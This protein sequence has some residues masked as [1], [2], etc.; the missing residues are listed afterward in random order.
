M[1]VPTPK[2]RLFFALWPD[3][4]VRQRM[5]EARN[6]LPPG[7]GR[8]VPATNLHLTLVF[9]G[10]VGD[11]VALC[12]RQAASRLHNQAFMLVLNKLGSWKKQQV[13][14]LAP[15]L[16]PEALLSLVDNLQAALQQCGLV[17][18]KRAFK[19]HVSVLRKLHQHIGPH[20]L[21]PISW[22]IDCFCLVESLPVAEGVHYH[23]VQSWQ[24]TK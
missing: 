12:A 14:W 21:Q 9:L 10:D 8:C 6:G 23:V 16:V 24:L 17:P 15:T 20:A 2:R 22:S 4:V 1:I 5:D 11:D 18:E 3:E 7:S 13:A 19:A